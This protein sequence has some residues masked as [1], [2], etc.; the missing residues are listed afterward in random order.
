LPGANVVI[1]KTKEFVAKCETSQLCKNIILGIKVYLRLSKYAH[2]QEPDAGC[3]RT[4]DR[5]LGS[6]ADLTNM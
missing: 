5:P 6:G 2:V 4:G 3:L 1:L